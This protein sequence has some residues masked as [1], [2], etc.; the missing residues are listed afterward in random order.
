MSGNSKL[1]SGYE[2]D[3]KVSRPLYVQR[4]EEGRTIRHYLLQD[5]AVDL[6]ADSPV[7]I[8]ELQK[9]ELTA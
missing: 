8:D 9:D 2:A 6:M 4:G 5:R 3:S 1:P 7:C